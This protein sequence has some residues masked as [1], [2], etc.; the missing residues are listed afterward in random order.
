MIALFAC[1]DQISE[2]YGIERGIRMH[3]LFWVK[4]RSNID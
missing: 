3:S 2:R 4:T 1:V